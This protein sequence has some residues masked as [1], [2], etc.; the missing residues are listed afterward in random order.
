MKRQFLRLVNYLIAV[1]LVVNPIF[2]GTV[3][4]YDGDGKTDI[5]VY[6]VYPNQNLQ[7]YWFVLNSSDYSFSATQWG[8]DAGNPTQIDVPVLGDFD[9]DGKTDVAIWRKQFAYPYPPTYFYILRSSDNTME[10]IQWG[11]SGDFEISQDYDGDG[12]TDIAVAR[13]GIANGLTWFILGSSRGYYIESVSGQFNIPIKGDY[14]GDGKADIAA[15]RSDTSYRQFFYIKKSSTNQISITQFGNGLTDYVVPGDYDG[16]GK[17]D[18]AVWRGKGET[19]TGRW[20]W[21][22]SSDGNWGSVQLGTG[23]TNYDYP[24]PGDYDGDGITDPAIYR[25]GYNAGNFNLQSYFYILGSKQGFYGV[26]WGL[27]TDESP[28]YQ[29]NVFVK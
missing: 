8:Q 14:D 16:D 5:V 28:I 4:D 15:V 6:R 11:N 21:I 7:K 20:Y 26:P 27:G 1:I 18:I 22:R 12:K 25:K 24:V 10:A 17:T 23:T 9:G 29:A 19:T 2:A 13:S 3:A